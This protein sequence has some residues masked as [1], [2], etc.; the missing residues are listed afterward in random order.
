MECLQ[1]DIDLCVLELDMEDCT[2]IDYY[3]E[4]EK[5]AVDLKDKDFQLATQNPRDTLNHQLMV[6]KLLDMED[7]L[8]LEHFE[9]MDYYSYFCYLLPDKAQTCLDL[10]D[11]R[12]K[13]ADLPTSFHEI[14]AEIIIVLS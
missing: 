2:E 11:S 7:L 4:D 5:V 10:L 14:F 3:F 13:A 6:V 9:S 1:E 8:M 12:D